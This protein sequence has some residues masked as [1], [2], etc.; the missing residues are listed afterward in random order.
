[1]GGVSEAAQEQCHYRLL[2]MPAALDTAQQHE[3]DQT[4]EQHTQTHKF[5]TVVI[6]P[7]KN[8]STHEGHCVPCEEHREMHETLYPL[9]RQGY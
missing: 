3:K 9:L 2:A 4:I 7:S 6:F 8:L 1:M 5:A